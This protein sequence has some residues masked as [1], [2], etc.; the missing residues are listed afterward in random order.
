MWTLIFGSILIGLIPVGLIFIATSGISDWAIKFKTG[1]KSG[2]VV[3]DV[4]SR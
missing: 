3:I 1:C 4:V 2:Y